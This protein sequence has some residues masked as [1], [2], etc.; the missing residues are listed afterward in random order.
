LPGPH[1]YLPPDELLTLESVRRIASE[2]KALKADP[3]R[4]IFVAGIFGWPLNEAALASAEYKIAPVPNPN[5]ADLQ[6][7]TVFDAWPICYDPDHLPS[8]ATTDPATGFDRAAAEWG[9]T[10]GLRNAAFVDEFRENGLKYSICE[11]DYANVLRGIGYA[12]P[13]MFQNLCLDFK[14][15]D[16]DRGV[17]SVQ[18]ICHVDWRF[19]A[20]DPNDPTR[21]VYQES[22]ASLPLCPAGATNGNVE[23]DCWQLLTDRVRCP[24]TGRWIRIL[25]TAEGIADQ[26]SLPRGTRVV[27]QCLAC[28]P[29]AP[30]T[31]V[32]A[33]CDYSL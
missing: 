18:P 14:L 19:P 3:E 32:V 20:P 25:R 22:P 23:A 30:G 11:R 6:H 31:P 29:S 8:P 24:T 1:R 28:P 5:T 13:K 17:A 9:A 10:A 33:G 7:P 21:I 15:V 12:M 27:A 16:S 4:Q 26:P 2:I